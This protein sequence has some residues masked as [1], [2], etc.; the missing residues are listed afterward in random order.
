MKIYI[1]GFIKGIGLIILANL[2]H[3]VLLHFFYEKRGIGIEE[4]QYPLS[5][6]NR[7]LSLMLTSFL[8]NRYKLSYGWGLPTFLF[9]SYIF[10][11]L[12]GFIEKQ[13]TNSHKLRHENS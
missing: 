9:G 6:V 3:A 12:L 1:K 4:G 2:I 8:I 11:F 10:P 7:L 13:K 5:M